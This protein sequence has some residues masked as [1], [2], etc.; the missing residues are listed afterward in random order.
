MII[1]NGAIYMVR[2]DDE[3]LEVVLTVGE[4]ETA[5]PYEMQPGD[6]LT[7]TVRAVPAEDSAP[8]LQIDSAPGSSRIVIRHEDTAELDYGMYS[9]DVQLTTADGIRKTVWP[10]LEPVRSRL[11]QRNMKNFNIASEVTIR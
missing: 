5:E 7:L 1:D 11:R 8:L 2:G 4:G 9:A 6:V 3:E 10:P